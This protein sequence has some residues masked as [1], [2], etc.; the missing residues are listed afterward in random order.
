MT[1]L[2]TITTGLAALL[3][4]AVLGHAASASGGAVS[5]CTPAPPPAD[6]ALPAPA[7]AVVAYPSPS[8]TEVTKTGAVLLASVDTMGAAGQV[9]FELGDTTVG[10]RCTAVQALPAVTGP[11]ARAAASTEAGARQAAICWSAWQIG[12]SC[13]AIGPG[14]CGRLPP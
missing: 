10:L 7:P 5:T 6:P 2:A 13:G 8:S 3:A 9:A 1:K 14:W 12:Q 11:Q 4:S